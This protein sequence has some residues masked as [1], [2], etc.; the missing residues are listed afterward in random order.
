MPHLT[1]RPPSPAP[2]SWRVKRTLWSIAEATLFRRSFHTWSRWRAFLLRL[3]GA[4]IGKNC[5]IRRTVK[6]Y[7][8]W[9]LEI[10]DLVIIGDRVKLYS[11]GKITL[12]SRCMIS[13]EAYLFASANDYTRPDLPLE[14]E[15]ITVGAD[16]WVCARAFIGPGVN[17]GAGA[18]AGACAVVTEDLP[19]G[20][21]AVGHKAQLPHPH[22][23]AESEVVPPPP[24]GH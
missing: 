5:V 6:V 1:H 14:R 11:V 21:T 22:G 19:P 13:Q 3:F 23:P 24:E 2:P 15:P 16:A 7:Y 18:V 17:I 4:K 9:Q 12:H 20:T 8:P 10:G